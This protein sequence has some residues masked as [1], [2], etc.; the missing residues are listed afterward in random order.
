LLWRCAQSCV[1][2]RSSTRPRAGDERD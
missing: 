1:F 2:A